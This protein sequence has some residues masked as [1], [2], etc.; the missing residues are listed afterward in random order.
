MQGGDSFT[1]Q[2]LLQSANKSSGRWSL[3]VQQRRQQRQFKKLRRWARWV[4]RATDIGIQCPDPSVMIKGLDV[5][6]KK[7]LGDHADISFRVS[8]LRYTLEVDTRPTLQGAKSLQQ[9]LLSE[10]E[11]VAYS[12][13]QGG[14][15]APV[16]K[17][18][19]TGA[20]PSTAGKP[21]GAGGGETGSPTRQPKAKAKTPC[22][23]Y[24]SDKG[25]SR[26]ASCTYSHDFTRK[27]RMGRCWTCGSTQHRQADCPTKTGGGSPKAGSGAKATPAVKAVMDATA[28]SSASTGPASTTSSSSV[29]GDVPA[30]TVPE[31]EI[32]SL[33]QEASAMLKEI[34]QLKTMSLT[35][36]QV[37]NQAVGVGCSPS[38][39][40]TGLLDSGASHPFREATEDELQDATQV[41][42]QLAGGREAV[43]AQGKSGTLLT[44]K[45]KDECSS[46]IV[47]LGA[48][49]QE[50]GCQVT[51]SRR[52]GL[53]I[54]H[55]IMGLSARR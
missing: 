31:A 54:R 15:A 50:L 37:Q 11:Q 40:R 13:R 33:L 44:K 24:L 9:A 14:T 20:P 32:K 45:T 17:A 10:L 19:A 46:P 51:W 35:I 41:T 52:G 27:E 48:L 39:G 1:D 38:T 22:K 4:A 25:C 8:M 34:R 2:V 21:D 47:P 43:L 42:V 3:R 6:V 18:I 29:T 12:G 36:T 26:G 28:M 49:V 16:V 55:P 7:I 53:V 5:I 30:P 23:F